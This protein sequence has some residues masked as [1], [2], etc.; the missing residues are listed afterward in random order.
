MLVAGILLEN[1]PWTAIDAFPPKWGSQMRAAALATIF[2]RCGLELDFGTM[3]KF[4]YPAIRLALIP[5]LV[6]ALF[7]AGLGVALF[8]MS[9]T[10]GLCM[11]FILKAVGPGLVVPAMF[12]LQKSSMGT[13][14]G[15]PS[16]VVIAASFDDAV[17]ITG[18][19]IFSTI[20]IQ[21]VGGT[22][23]NAAWTIAEGPM[24]V[25]FGIVG[26]IL[27]GFC[28]G[29][30]VL[31][32]THIK[33]FVA[34]YFTGLL[35][36][37]FLSYYNLLSGGAL[38]AL[39]T[40]LVASNLWER[41]IPRR[42]SLGQSFSYS[43][44][45]E[46]TMSII[47]RWIMEPILFVTVG[48]TLNFSMLTGG[49]VPKAIAIVV[50]GVTVRMLFTF[51]S[52]SGFTY[53][54]K[55][56]LF[57]CIAW[58]PKAT[59]QAALS[60]AP[61]ML[62]KQYK[63]GDPNYEQWVRWGNQ[64]LTTGLFAIIICGTLGV[65]AIHFSAA[66]LLQP[67]KN[68]GKGD[69]SEGDDGDDGEI[70]PDDR[71]EQQLQ[72]QLKQ[73]LQPSNA[74]TLDHDNGR[75]IFPTAAKIDGIETYSMPRASSTGDVPARHRPGSPPHIP[76]VGSLDY[77]A[78][79]PGSP[80]PPLGTVMPT[81]YQSSVQ[82][83]VAGDDLDLV[84][85]YIAAIQRLTAAVHAGE[86]QYSREDVVSLSERVVYMQ[87][88]VESEIGRREPSVRELFRTA[89][90]IGV[91]RAAGQPRSGSA[92]SWSAL[93][94]ARTGVELRQRNDGSRNGM[95]E[96]SPTAPLDENV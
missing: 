91:R 44:D 93:S 1:I 25:V 76:R 56:K 49:D 35:L 88:R 26:G 36:M 77:S 37:F 55:E 78:G 72:Q 60:A 29:V 19:A 70:T 75:I 30:T 11:G 18:F 86:Q 63:V 6:E 12:R 31:W 15:I 79:R 92:G 10:L 47:W 85:E 95:A 54:I 43:P 53:T 48:S 83:F 46:R 57:Y 80:P 69:G 94:N 22:T 27:A 24:Q 16:T 68:D 17:A 13:D 50:A 90:F 64:I 3:R 20:A 33:R 51:I 4:K 9:Y 62:I 71:G 14:Q 58:T 7:D 32:N 87:Q 74:G 96:L 45:C 34:L 73:Q 84:A 66:V 89:S 61:L 40:G 59:V 23:A 65:L 67:A 8:G 41:G 82:N 5:G 52:M 28:I 21:S 38:G 2:L 42:F 81:S 39:F